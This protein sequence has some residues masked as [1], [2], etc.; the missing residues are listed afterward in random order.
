MIKERITKVSFEKL[1]LNSLLE[2]NPNILVV[3][4]E[5]VDFYIKL[6]IKNDI[7]NLV[8][9][10]NGAINRKISNPPVFSRSS[11]FND[12]S[13]SCIYLDDAT[14][15]DTN[16]TVGW[17]V[18]TQDRHYILDYY[19]I[20]LRISEI[21]HIPSNKVIYY[22]S[23]AGGFIS[24]MLATLHK[25][26][27][28]IPNNPQ[29]WVRLESQTSR[30]KNL[31]NEIF[32]GMSEKDIFSKFKERFSVIKMMEKEKYIP[33]M[34][35]LLNRYSDK[36]YNEQYKPFINYIDKRNM[37]Q[38][39]NIEFIMYHSDKGHNGIYSREK[40]ASLINNIFESK[41]PKKL[42]TLFNAIKIFDDH[43]NQL[44]EIKSG[45]K[46][47]LPQMYLKENYYSEANIIFKKKQGTTILVLHNKY[48]NKK[49]KNY[50]QLE[51]LVN[52]TIYLTEDLSLNNKQIQIELNNL[53]QN[54]KI[55]IRVRSLKNLKNFSW[56]SAS[57]LNLVKY[58][59]E[60]DNSIKGSYV[61]SNSSYSIVNHSI[62]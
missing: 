57:L 3:E 23:S 26:S 36:D 9:F 53:N 41:H 32:P 42:F 18:G 27:L 7:E 39:D 49:G 25:G 24:L 17:G 2:A 45:G 28:A 19:Q 10:S 20:I 13:A 14:I 55:K 37:A 6:K 62:Q 31:Y 4:K 12:Y 5:N 29:V 44:Q 1:N 51:V 54:D 30:A 58:Y 60:Y 38:N 40:T 22:G 43:D 8:V 47:Y 21:L 56:S 48:R 16:I 46:V 50:L 52:S 61:N 35:Y 11:W 34:I 59:E 15:H 33:N